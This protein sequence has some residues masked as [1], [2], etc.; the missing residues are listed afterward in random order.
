MNPNSQADSTLAKFRIT[1]GT[2]KQVTL[3]SLDGGGTAYNFSI[4][5]AFRNESSTRVIPV[6]MHSHLH[7]N[8]INTYNNTIIFTFSLS[9][10]VPRTI[11]FP[12]GQYSINAF[13][14]YLVA[15]MTTF[16]GPFTYAKSAY[17]ED[18]TITSGGDTFQFELSP[19]TSNQRYMMST[20]F[21]NGYLAAQRMQSVTMIYT[22][23]V[24]IQSARMLPNQ[25]N[26]SYTGGDVNLDYFT[27]FYIDSPTQTSFSFGA[28]SGQFAN[29]QYTCRPD[30][31][32]SSVAVRLVDVFG[33]SLES[34]CSSDGTTFFIMTIALVE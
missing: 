26:T 34:Y 10:L 27:S 8:N 30:A 23:I 2:T 21:A 29:A 32:S 13:F 28:A 22:P 19:F 25:G 17:N 31:V 24:Y 14:T 18:V 1:P 12:V 11:I 33:Q 20:P 15:Q 9:P 5:K 7:I 16:G 4:S 6:S 3:N